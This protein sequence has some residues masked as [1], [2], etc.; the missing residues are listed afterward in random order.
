MS[1]NG[2]DYI[3]IEL[4]GGWFG[5]MVSKLREKYGLLFFI[6]YFQIG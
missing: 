1:N 2:S 6:F 5:C 3:T 4:Q